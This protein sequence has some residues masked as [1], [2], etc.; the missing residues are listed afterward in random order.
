MV[1]H[2]ELPNKQGGT[3]DEYYHLTEDELDLLHS[4]LQSEADTLQ[5][6]TDR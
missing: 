6:V 3:T 4:A 2:N 1:D 5:S